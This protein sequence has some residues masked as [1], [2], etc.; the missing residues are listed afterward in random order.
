MHSEDKLI[1]DTPEQIALEFPL[2]GIGSRFLAIAFDTL[3]QVVVTVL[4]FLALLALIV[5]VPRT[6]EHVSGSA[7]PALMVL[8]WFLI[9]WGYF[10]IFEIVWKGQTPGKRRAGIRVIHRSG[11]PLNA[12]EA[13]ARNFMRVVDGLPAL[14]GVGIVTMM[15][16]RYQRRLGDYVAGT[17]VVHD[18]VS[19]G[20]PH[21]L[22][23][24]RSMGALAG[25]TRKITPD[26]L[27]VIESYLQRRF[28]LPPEVRLAASQRLV[29]MVGEKTALQPEAGHSNDDFLE[30]IARQ[31]RDIARLR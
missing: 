22:N 18:R 29:A 8:F 2:A 6:V 13:I 9:Y 11:R 10:A 19:T 7:I 23:E 3:L 28:E 14:Y 20:T 15:L 27:V 4:A 1:V 25:A 21:V 12:F 30:D 5:V 26:E 17:V 31:V 24:V 16:N